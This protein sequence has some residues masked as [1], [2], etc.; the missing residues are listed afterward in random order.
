MPFATDVTPFTG[1]DDIADFM[2]DVYA[3]FA[4]NTMGWVNSAPALGTHPDQEF[5]F[6]R[7]SGVTPAPPYAFY[8]TGANDMHIFSGTGVDT[9][10][11]IYDQPGNPMNCPLTAG[12][13]TSPTSLAALRCL[14]INDIVGPFQAYWLFGPTDASYIHCVVKVS[15]RQYR[16][17]HVGLLSGL[18]SDLD[19]ASFYVTGHFW[20]ML[21]PDAH[22]DGLAATQG[23]HAPYNQVHRT[24]FGCNDRGNDTIG[25]FAQFR[26]QWIYA[27]GLNDGNGPSGEDID[28]YH[29]IGKDDLTSQGHFGTISK[30][31]G[32]VNSANNAVIF[33]VGAISGY[34][35]GLGACLFS[36]DR[37]FS[38][39]AV[40]LIPIYV[41]VNVPFAADD[42]LG[43][44]AQVPDVFRVNMR[45]LSAEQEITVGGDTYVVFPLMNKDSENTLDG[46]GYSGYEGL[47]Y[48]KIVA[49][50]T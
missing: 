18:H 38:S 33:G 24:P 1:D 20:G 8:R 2:N 27:P 42:R 4:V 23:E 41:G 11:E 17:F 49:A 47:A 43:V 28:W 34:A 12:F 3:D 39:N 29:M 31:V 44:I 40:P 50:V 37:T 10:E 25:P 21:D 32:G 36:A 30:P 26:G 14:F 16:H 35:D 5:W 7:G 6:H 48:K 46:E 45:S 13:D 22:H 19:A 15:S 9:G